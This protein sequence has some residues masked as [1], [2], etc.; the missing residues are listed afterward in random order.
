MVIVNLDRYDWEYIFVN[1]GSSDN[2][3]EVLKI[4]AD[5]NSRVKVLDFSRNFGKEAALTAGVHYATASDAVICIDADLQHPPELIPQMV[6]L[7]DKGVDIV[8]TIRTSIDR[9]PL[10]RR[11]GSHIFYWLMSKISGLEMV[12]Q[13]TDF[14]LYDRKVIQIFVL[15]TERNRLFRGIMDWLGFDKA[16][17]NFRADARAAGSPAYSYSK[18]WALAVNSITSFSLWP[19]RIT[20]YLGVLIVGSSVLLML[21]MLLSNFFEFLSYQYS[22]IALVVVFNTL[23]IGIVLMGIGL[24]AIYIGAIHTEVI[25][26][27]LYV[28]KQELNLHKINRILD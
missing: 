5:S 20:G 22:S 18:L 6:E 9:Q 2:S 26:R 12:S 14:R 8:A 25:N 10:L 3:F 24:T 16:Y 11:V 1:D 4:L 17:L 19:L 27:P 7:W 21:W 28:L 13:T 15:A 23:L